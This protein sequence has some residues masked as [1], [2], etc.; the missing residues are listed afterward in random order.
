MSFPFLKI[1]L[2]QFC[3]IWGYLCSSP[4]RGVLPEHCTSCTR[5]IYSPP[6]YYLLEACLSYWLH[7]AAKLER[8]SLWKCV[9]MA[10]AFLNL[11]TEHLANTLLGI[12]WDQTWSSCPPYAT[13][14]WSCYCYIFSHSCRNRRCSM[15]QITAVLN[16]WLGSISSAHR[17]LCRL[18][19][20]IPQ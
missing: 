8:R 15:C 3:Q 12:K 9:N 13:V 10:N 19:W 17:L 2:G 6:P 1:R 14:L 4:G 20:A 7:W 16:K 18:Q 5:W 11:L